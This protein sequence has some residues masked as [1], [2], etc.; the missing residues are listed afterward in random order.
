MVH[1]GYVAEERGELDLARALHRD[2]W[3]RSRELRDERCAAFALEG[4]AG[5]AAAEGDGALAAALLAR[6]AQTRAVTSFELTGAERR[7]VERAEAAARR[8]I[9]D[10]RFDEVMSGGQAMGFDDAV[11]RLLSAPSG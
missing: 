5:V 3:Q 9:G 11:E 2:A 1:L 6:A 4:L 10:R 7:D 8:A